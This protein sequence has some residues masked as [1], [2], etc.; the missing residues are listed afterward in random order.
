MGTLIG[1]FTSADDPHL[2]HLVPVLKKRGLPFIRVAVISG[3][4]EPA[5]QAF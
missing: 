4:V 1:L 5:K 2:A 3:T